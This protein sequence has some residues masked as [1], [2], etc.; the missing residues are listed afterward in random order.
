MTLVSIIWSREVSAIRRLLCAVNYREC[1]GTAASCPQCGG[2]R[3]GASP[4]SEVPL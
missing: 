3:N 4:L 1:F 2:F